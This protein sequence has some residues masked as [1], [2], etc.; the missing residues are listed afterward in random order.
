MHKAL[1][2]MPKEKKSLTRRQKEKK[3]QIREHYGGTGTML[4]KTTT[5]PTGRESASRYQQEHSTGDMDWTVLSKSQ[6]K[7]V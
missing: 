5:G 4:R 6:W 3:M 1:G 2:S 7:C